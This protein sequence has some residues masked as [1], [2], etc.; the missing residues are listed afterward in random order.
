MYSYNSYFV[1]NMPKKTRKVTAL[2]EVFNYSVW[3]FWSASMLAICVTLLLVNYKHHIENDRFLLLTTSYGIMI[4]ES[5]PE[6]LLN[7]DTVKSMQFLLLTWIPMS[8]L[9]GM[10]YQ[11]NLLALMT[12]KQLEKPIETF[13]DIVDRDMTM[14]MT[15]TRSRSYTMLKSS[16]NPTVRKAF[17]KGVVENEGIFK[18]VN[19][20]IPNYVTKI[21]EE[22]KGVQNVLTIVSNITRYLKRRKFV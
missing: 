13:Q 16:P 20:T 10:A 2:L 12:K 3:I 7:I 1:A 18:Y 22:G 4:N 11:S 8:F 5:I 9:I 15:S 17:Q 6:R 21:V 19:D 14:F